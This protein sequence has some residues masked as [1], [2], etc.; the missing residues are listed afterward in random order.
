M[1]TIHI[2]SGLAIVLLVAFGETDI[3][4]Q[5]HKAKK[6]KHSSKQHQNKQNSGR[7]LRDYTYNSHSSYRHDNGNR[8]HSHEYCHHN[9]VCRVEH[10]PAHIERSVPRHYVRR[11]P[12]RN[13]IS[14]SVGFDSFYFCEGYFYS[15]R[16]GKGFITVELDLP[17]VRRAPQRCCNRSMGE[18]NVLSSGGYVYIPHANGYYRVRET[19]GNELVL[20]INN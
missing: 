5:H 1:K 18:R 4:A 20:R 14:F 6:E 19:A 11:L 15:Y 3:A 12:S 13:Y 2:I 8:G 17:S 16:P 10:R 7:K 9:E